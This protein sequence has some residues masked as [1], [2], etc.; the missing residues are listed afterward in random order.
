MQKKFKVANSKLHKKIMHKMALKMTNDQFL[1]YK[2][3]MSYCILINLD[4]QN[5]FLHYDFVNYFS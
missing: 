4:T 1:Y 5:F 2:I 3:L